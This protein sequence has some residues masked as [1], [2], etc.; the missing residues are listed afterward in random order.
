MTLSAWRAGLFQQ[1]EGRRGAG[2]L[3]RSFRVQLDRR[4]PRRPAVLSARVADL[5]RPIRCPQHRRGTLLVERLPPLDSTAFTRLLW[6]A[7]RRRDVLLELAEAPGTA[8]AVTCLA[9]AGALV[10]LPAR[11]P[12]PPGMDHHLDEHLRSS[13]CHDRLSCELRSVRLRRAAHDQLWSSNARPAVSVLLASRRPGDIMFAIEQIGR[14]D[15]VDAQIVVGLHGDEW[16]AGVESQLSCLASVSAVARFDA[17]TPLGSILN[18]MTARADRDLVT[19]WDDDDW[20]GV[21]HLADLVR[22]YDYSGAD[23]VGKAAEFVRLEMSD[24]TVRR[25]ATGAESYS[26]TLAGGTLLTSKGWLREIGGWAAVP[27]G[28]DR[29]LLDATRR[30]GGR[31][32]RTHG[33]QYVLRRRAGDAHT[34]AAADREFLAG[35]AIRREGLDLE[36]AD[37]QPVA[38]RDNLVEE[39]NG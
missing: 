34:W 2:L 39:L 10:R 31:S 1:L 18:E 22:A 11:L 3:A 6:R 14:Q 29:A 5:A 32:Y 15:G 8:D 4:P 16:P 7:R 27:R 21:D 35:V 30:R 37:I 28:V 24:L 23:V 12:A 17:T 26:T 36:L 20:Y 33:F 38:D 9:A 25:F 13:A 19:K